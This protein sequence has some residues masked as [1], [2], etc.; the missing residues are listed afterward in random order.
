MTIEPNTEMLIG[1]TKSLFNMKIKFIK[2]KSNTLS[3]ILMILM[4]EE[5]EINGRQWLKM[6]E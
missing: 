2:K 1:L 5:F 3:L 6:E 4:K